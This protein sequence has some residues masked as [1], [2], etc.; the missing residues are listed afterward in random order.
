MRENDE[1]GGTELHSK[2]TRPPHRSPRRNL[3]GHLMLKRAR[4]ESV[5]LGLI[6]QMMEPLAARAARG[7]FYRRISVQLCDA[8][9][10]EKQITRDDFNGV[11][12][13]SQLMVLA[14]FAS[15]PFLLM[16]DL[17]NARQA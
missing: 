10:L 9:P 8:Q 15:M 2:A 14:C 11:L 5:A 4:G 7:D 1:T 16:Q 17:Q 13:G 3:F 6:R 12:A